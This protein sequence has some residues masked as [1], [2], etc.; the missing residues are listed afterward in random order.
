MWFSGVS[1]RICFVSESNDDKIIGQYFSATVF[2]A[3]QF[4]TLV[5]FS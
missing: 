5:R 2:W 3:T 4:S 1:K